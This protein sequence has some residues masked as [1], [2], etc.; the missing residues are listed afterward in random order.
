ML[1][2]STPIRLCQYQAFLGCACTLCQPLFVSSS[3]ER[4]QKMNAHITLAQLF[5]LVPKKIS[6]KVPTP[7]Y[8][9][10]NDTPIAISEDSTAICFTSGYVWYK[11]TCGD[12]VFQIHR[13]TSYTY[14]SVDEN[15]T[16]SISKEEML[17]MEW[18][19]AVMIIGESRAEH[20][21]A[22]REEVKHRI[23]LNYEDND[24]W[25]SISDNETE[26]PIFQNAAI[27]ELLSVLTERQKEI[28]I[29]Y[30][31]NELKQQ[32]IADFL[33]ISIQSVCKT[34]KTAIKKLRS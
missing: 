24:P 15:N 29:M 20:N 32:E 33:G 8:L 9:R 11:A 13:C 25:E 34:L 16:F 10:E 27:T 26:M 6:G 18:F 23:D 12:T 3:L 30:Y 5:T 1:S 2:W 19:F 31:I 22:D 7:K 17:S 28:I 4:I 14:D 21:Q